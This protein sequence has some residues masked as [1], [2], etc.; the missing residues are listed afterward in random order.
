MRNDLWQ[1]HFLSICSPTGWT[2]DDSIMRRKESTQLFTV[3]NS[4]LMSD[5]IGIRFMYLNVVLK[6]K[7]QENASGN[8]EARCRK[9]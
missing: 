7:G 3:S 2:F 5:E 8:D 9:D 4:P 1:A 6:E